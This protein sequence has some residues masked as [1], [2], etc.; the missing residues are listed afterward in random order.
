[1]HDDQALQNE[2]I[3]EIMNSLNHLDALLIKLENAPTDE[4]ILDEIFR[5]LHS[6]KGL[7]SFFEDQSIESLSHNGEHLLELLKCDKHKINDYTVG[8]LLEVNDMMKNLLKAINEA[9]INHEIICNN[10]IKKLQNFIDNPENKNPNRNSHQLK[11]NNQIKSRIK[12]NSYNQD[13]CIQVELTAL[14]KL[15]KKVEQLV[16]LNNQISSFGFQKKSN[17]F[18]QVNESLNVVTSQ[19]N[20]YVM[21]MR[22]QPIGLIWNTFSHIIHDLA[23][24]SGKQIQL[25]IEGSDIT[26]DKTSMVLVKGP[27]M[28]VIRNAVDHG[29]ETSEQRIAKGKPSS[30]LIKLN[31]FRTLQNTVIEI[32]DDGK[33]FQLKKIIHKAETLGLAT[34]NQLDELSSQDIL[35]F[36]FEP[37]FTTKDEVTHLSGRG[38]GMDVVRSNVESIGGAVEIESQVDKGSTLRILIPFIDSI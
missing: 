14:N 16:S 5:D 20:H 29:I 19:I 27:I 4:A 37:G 10:L 23:F 25:E 31:A 32:S 6:I 34:K 3:D 1:M 35:S 38:I 2:M 18:K 28:Q 17:R 15:T 21:N 22:L 11:L 26:I 12:S 33:G 8:L 24:A 13:H 7:A 9:N 36:V 30:G